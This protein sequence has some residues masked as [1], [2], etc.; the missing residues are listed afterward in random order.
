MRRV[1]MPK[2]KLPQKPTLDA[3]LVPKVLKASR[4]LREPGARQ[5]DSAH[6]NLLRDAAC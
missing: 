2:T 1:P 3:D 4:E 5:R 6:R